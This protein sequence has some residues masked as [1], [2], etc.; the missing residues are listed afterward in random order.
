MVFGEL[1]RYY[2]SDNIN[3]SR[4][5]LRGC[6]YGNFCILRDSRRQANVNPVYTDI[7]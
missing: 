2:Y 7:L 4:E 3:P 1:L 5:Y 6:L